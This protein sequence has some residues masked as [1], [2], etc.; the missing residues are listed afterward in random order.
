MNYKELIIN[1]NFNKLNYYEEI[2]L[3][4]EN[5]EEE[6]NLNKNNNFEEI[7]N[8]IFNELENPETFNILN[9]FFKK[10]TINIKK[11]FILSDLFD[12]ILNFLFNE[13]ILINIF[14]FFKNLISNSIKIIKILLEKNILKLLYYYLEL[15]NYLLIHYSLKIIKIIINYSHY[16]RILLFITGFFI[17]ISNLINLKN[18]NLNYK[19][20]SHLLL[21]YIILDPI[22]GIYGYSIIGKKLPSRKKIKEFCNKFLLNNNSKFLLNKFLKEGNNYNNNNLLWYCLEQ[23]LLSNNEYLIYNSLLS[24]SILSRY[25][26][27]S[28]KIIELTS[29]I[30]LFPK[31]LELNDN[32]KW[33]TIVT[34]SDL[35]FFSNNEFS[36]KIWNNKFNFNLILNLLI[37][38]NNNKILLSNLLLLTNII[39][40]YNEIPLFVLNENLLIFINNNLINSDFKLK[41]EIIWLFISIINIFPFNFFKN[42]FNQQIF[43]SLIYLIETSNNQIKEAILQ[44]FCL[45]IEEDFN[46]KNFFNIEFIDILN[47]LND[48]NEY[49]TFLLNKIEN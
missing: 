20:I 36:L 17:K 1:N 16:G 3:I 29:I 5:E 45:F 8:L 41:I 39:N 43:D 37:N 12:E 19:Y 47:N 34:L 27:N 31:F 15:N 49:T 7:E 23:F 30:N 9:N 11:S 33:A 40:S 42:F 38:N 2:E 25:N 46:F 28:N 44:T 22:N 13:N 48:F 35:T 14:N 32:I 24:F 10:T 21:K 6:E 26:N 18:L 4:L